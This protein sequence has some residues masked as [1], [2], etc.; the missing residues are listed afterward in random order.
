VTRLARCSM[1]ILIAAAA[2]GTASAQSDKPWD[3]FYAGLGAGEASHG[4]CSSWT[5]NDA[6]PVPAS[7]NAFYNQICPG[8]STLLGGVQVGENFQYKHLFWG[9]GAD[10]DI[11]RTTS[12]NQ[13]LKYGGE[14]PPR[15]TYTF[16][17]KSSPNAFAVIAPRFGYAGRQWL[18]YLRGGAIITTG[19]SDAMINY[20]PPGAVKPT[21]SF[22]GGKSYA[23]SGWVA[24]GGVEYGLNGAWSI[25]AEYLHM[26]LGKG[27]SSTATC[28]GAAGACT[29]FSG[30]SFDNLHTGFTS[31]VIRIGINYWFDYWT[32]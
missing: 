28:S 11:W 27:S 18:P 20:T 12:N 3:G 17:G 25:T 15:G 13:S 32:P 9:I 16:F 23:S 5:P 2:A 21:A 8:G 24:G 19:S 4:A 31:N 29:A 26:D 6:P 30:T 10:V 1:A 14:A 22:S 7:G